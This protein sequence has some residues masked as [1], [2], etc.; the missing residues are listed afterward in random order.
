LEHI[1]QLASELSVHSKNDLEKLVMIAH[2]DPVAELMECL[3]DKT[4]E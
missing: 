1:H 3:S 4:L 2:K